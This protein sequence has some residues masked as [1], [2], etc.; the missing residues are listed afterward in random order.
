MSRVSEKGNDWVNEISLD[1]VY[2]I[3]S[4]TDSFNNFGHGRIINGFD[5]SSMVV[6]HNMTINKHLFLK[7]GGF[8]EEFIGWG[9]EDTYFGARL[10]SEG[11]F[12]I[13]L[14]NCGVYH[15][16]HPPRSGSLEKQEKEYSEN[17]KTYKNLINKEI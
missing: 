13:P 4:N 7:V 5:L 3:V 9:L 15:I 2:E 1:G 10:I 8:S 14:L 12:V 16:N 11:G 17:L 6:G